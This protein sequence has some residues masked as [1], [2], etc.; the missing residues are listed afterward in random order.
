M[1][2][3]FILGCTLYLFWNDVIVKTGDESFKILSGGIL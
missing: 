1:G 2:C 3:C